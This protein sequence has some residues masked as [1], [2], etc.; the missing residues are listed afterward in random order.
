MI[1]VIGRLQAP[2]LQVLRPATMLTVMIG[3]LQA[4]VLKINVGWL[5]KALTWQRFANHPLKSRM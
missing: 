1:T 2:V 5:G 3:R 4:P